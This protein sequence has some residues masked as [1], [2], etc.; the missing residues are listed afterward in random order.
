M[1]NQELIDQLAKFFQ[2]EPAV[3]AVYAFGSQVQGYASKASDFDLAVMVK[4]KDEFSL[5][6]LLRKMAQAEL[7]LPGELDLVV[8]DQHSSPLLLFQI[9]K[10]GHKVYQKKEQLRIQL[11]ADIMHRFYDTQYLRDIYQ[12]YLGQSLT[13]DNSNLS[14]SN[15][16]RKEKYVS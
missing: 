2:N 5:R 8:V 11:E 10:T 1:I 7:A 6:K 3:L 14:R 9:I 16:S 4:G 13:S 15:L 12:A